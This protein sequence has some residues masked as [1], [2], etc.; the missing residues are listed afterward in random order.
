MAE[1][2][3]E[4]DKITERELTPELRERITLSFSHI[5][6]NDMHVTPDERTNWNAAA[7]MPDATKYIAGKMSSTDKIKLDAIEDKA[8]NYI[9]PKSG[10]EYGIYTQ[11]KVDE[12]GH[13]IEGFNPSKLNITVTNSELLNGLEAKEYAKSLNAVLTGV[14]Q[15]PTATGTNKFQLVNVNYLE[16][17]LSTFR[18]SII[19]ELKK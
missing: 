17:T 7:N 13:V 6:N 1:Y 15:C 11:V 9:H 19:A 3:E 2:S 16:K 14:P 10:V 5:R 8:N 4:K 18:E 12:N